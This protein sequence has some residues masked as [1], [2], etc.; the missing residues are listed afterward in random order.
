MAS[1]ELARTHGLSSKEVSWVMIF[2]IL[3][4]IPF[5]TLWLWPKLFHQ[6]IN[7]TILPQSSRFWNK[8]VKIR[9]NTLTKNR[10]C[11]SLE[12]WFVG[13]FFLQNNSDSKKWFFVKNFHTLRFKL[14]CKPLNGKLKNLWNLWS[15]IFSVLTSISEESGFVFSFAFRQKGCLVAVS[16]WR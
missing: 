10:F 8:K 14:S 2:V 12:Y 3:D 9:K 15:H 5:R 6:S 7:F 11:G 16:K 13:F 1:L 4:N